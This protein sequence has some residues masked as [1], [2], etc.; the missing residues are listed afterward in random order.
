MKLY[1]NMPHTSIKVGL[2]DGEIDGEI[3]RNGRPYLVPMVRKKGKVGG[4]GK[5]LEQNLEGAVGEQV[6]EPTMELCE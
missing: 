3:H 6:L 5:V 1:S 2:E 4:F